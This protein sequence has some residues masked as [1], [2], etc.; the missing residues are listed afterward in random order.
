[1]QTLLTSYVD[2][3]LKTS[4][5]KLYSVTKQIDVFSWLHLTQKYGSVCTDMSKLMTTTQLELTH[6]VLYYHVKKMTVVHCQLRRILSRNFKG[7]CT[8]PNSEHGCALYSSHLT[9]ND[10]CGILRGMNI[11]ID[12]AII[13]CGLQVS[14]CFASKRGSKVCWGVGA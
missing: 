9:T 3:N 13:Y 12:H 4:S 2:S 7:P 5:Y 1:M 6:Q 14:K 10:A 11:A 8:L